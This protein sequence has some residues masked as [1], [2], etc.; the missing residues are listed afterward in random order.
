MTKGISVLA[1]V[2]C[3]LLLAQYARAQDASGNEPSREVGLSANEVPDDPGMMR[4]PTPI[5]E[6]ETW[7]SPDDY[8][9]QAAHQWVQASFDIE[10]T[11]SAADAITGC[12][13]AAAT[14]APAELVAAACRAV[15]ARGKF[16]H[17]LGR[18]G[19]AATARTTFSV[20]FRLGPP[21]RI[22]VPAVSNPNVPS[23]VDP[24]AATMVHHTPA[25]FPNTAVRARIDVS[26]TGAPT[27]C[28]ILVSSG[29]DKGD[30]AVCE[31]L[32][33]QKF[34]PARDYDGAPTAFNGY[35]MNLTVVAW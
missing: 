33:M 12:G 25:F 19:T 31:H 26:A 13:K 11:V 8:P 4:A 5:G 16:L 1:A 29:T 9:V 10:V 7:L 23:L 35:R 24:S 34:V 2:L 6:Y 30:A 3:A 18:T 21:K 32:R 27:R 28:T 20:F 14:P 15:T 22:F 17:G